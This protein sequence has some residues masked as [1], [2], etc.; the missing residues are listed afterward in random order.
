MAS[1]YPPRPPHLRKRS[2]PSSSSSSSF[3]PSLQGGDIK[4]EKTNPI[5][6]LVL[7]SG[8]KIT[9]TAHGCMEILE[10]LHKHQALDSS[11]CYQ[12]AI[13]G[14]MHML[15]WLHNHGCPWNAHTTR[16]AAERGDLEMLYYL[17]GNGCVFD[18]AAM[19]ASLR[20]GHVAAMEFF[21]NVLQIEWNGAETWRWLAAYHGQ[22]SI[23][24]WAHENGFRIDGVVSTA[25]HE[26]HRNR[27][28]K[29]MDVIKF[30]FKNDPNA[31]QEACK[32]AIQYGEPDILRWALDNGA[33]Y[34]KEELQLISP[35]CD[36][37]EEAR[38]R[39]RDTVAK[40][41]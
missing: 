32:A 11:M 24:Q 31:P 4:R 7:L 41:E 37:S 14:D 27:H 2:F 39:I 38:N 1:R 22:L 35:P 8:L 28:A 30:L 19:M 9:A 16:A 6:Q 21:M 20:G 34:D 33:S 23:L 29:F 13:T 15:Q 40:L 25:I 17:Y 10:Y 18:R 36:L 5:K 26:M 3:T 12:A